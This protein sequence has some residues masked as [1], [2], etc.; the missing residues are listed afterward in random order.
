MLDS[1]TTKMKNMHRRIHNPQEMLTRDPF[2]LDSKPT[3]FVKAPWRK[4]EQ[5]P[6]KMELGCVLTPGLAPIPNTPSRTPLCDGLLSEVLTPS[7]AS[8]KL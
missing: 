4:S 5:W 2:M 6:G 1:G 3:A 7:N 8:A